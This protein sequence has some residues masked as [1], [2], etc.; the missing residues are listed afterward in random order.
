MYASTSC[1]ALVCLVSAR[2]LL[3]RSKPSIEVTNVNAPAADCKA[4]K[5]GRSGPI[6]S[7]RWT[8]RRCRR[9]RPAS[10]VGIQVSGRNDPQLLLQVPVRPLV[11]LICS[12]AI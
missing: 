3:Y 4:A 7:A 11:L 9:R 10:H 2:G 12:T 6:A 1:G 8:S 5:P